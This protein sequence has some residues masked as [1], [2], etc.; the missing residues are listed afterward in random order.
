MNHWSNTVSVGTRASEHPS[1]TA[2]GAWLGTAPS[3]NG[4][5][6]V[7]GQTGITSGSPASAPIVR[8]CIVWTMSA[9]RWFPSTSMSTAVDASGTC[10]GMIGEK[11]SYR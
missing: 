6:R 4:S 7:T 2:N 9:N 10:F 1:T 8:I 3:Y 5:P 11:G